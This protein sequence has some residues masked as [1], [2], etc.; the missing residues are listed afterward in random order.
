MDYNIEFRKCNSEFKRSILP[1][2]HDNAFENWF[3]IFLLRCQEVIFPQPHSRIRIV[4][5]YL[6][7]VI[8]WCVIFLISLANLLTDWWKKQTNKWRQWRRHIHTG[9]YFH[10]FLNTWNK[11]WERV[12]CN[13]M[14]LLV[15][16]YHFY[17][18]KYKTSIHRWATQTKHSLYTH[19]K[20]KRC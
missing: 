6:R 1:S 7:V 9:T 16:L 4:F 17:K 13:P 8:H 11:Y 10:G 15:C 12:Q 5:C 2:Y 14:A 20:K 18:N 3:F 19:P